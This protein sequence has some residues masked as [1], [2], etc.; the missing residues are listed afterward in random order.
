MANLLAL[1]MGILYLDEHVC[2][3]LV[4]IPEI[5]KSLSALFPRVPLTVSTK[6]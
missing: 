3:K 6:A 2:S 4:F 1:S 5:S